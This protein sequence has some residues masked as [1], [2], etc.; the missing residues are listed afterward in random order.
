MEIT[1]FANILNDQT[2]KKYPKPMLADECM[3]ILFE[4]SEQFGHLISHK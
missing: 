3:R 4:F 1:F 2:N